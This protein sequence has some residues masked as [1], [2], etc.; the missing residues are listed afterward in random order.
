LSR[1]WLEENLM[2]LIN[3]IGNLL[4]L[5]LAGFWLAVGYAAA[6]LLCCLLIITIPFGVQAF[7]LAAYSFWPFGR[8]IIE[9]RRSNEGLSLLGNIIWFVV[10]GWWLAVA[11][12]ATGIA[13]CVTIIGIPFGIASFKMALL[14]LAPFGRRVVTVEELETLPDARVLIRVAPRSGRP[15]RGHVTRGGFGGRV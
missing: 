1:W 14:S 4:W 2:A 12:V 7:K 9:D 3:L 15:G 8:V 6:G 10:A 11:H 13:L 5:I